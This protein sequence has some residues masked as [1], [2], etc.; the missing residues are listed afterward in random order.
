LTV[1]LA[2]SND[3]HAVIESFWVAQKGWGVGH[4][5]GIH[6]HGTGIDAQSEGAIL[7]ERSRKLVLICAE[8]SPLAH[9]SFLFISSSMARTIPSGVRILG[10]ELQA[11]VLIDHGCISP[12]RKTTIA[13]CIWT[14]SVTMGVCALVRVTVHEFLLTE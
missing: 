3:R 6:L 12:L 8:I 1:V 11:Q 10:L 2:E 14:V 5:T 13:A 9:K 7:H 4:A